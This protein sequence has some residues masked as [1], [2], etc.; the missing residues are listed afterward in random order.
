MKKFMLSL[1][2][3]TPLVCE[4]VPYKGL[5]TNIRRCENDEVICYTIQSLYG[6]GISCKFKEKEN[7]HIPSNVPVPEKE[8]YGKLQKY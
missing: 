5:L 1:L 8:S 4:N 2:L 6:D 3:V 7:V